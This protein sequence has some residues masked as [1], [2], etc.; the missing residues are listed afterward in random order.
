MLGLVM[1]GKLTL[2]NIGDS[3]ALLI[4]NSH[5]VELTSEHNYSRLDEFKRITDQKW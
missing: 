3:T 2:A 1:N 5:I 4:K